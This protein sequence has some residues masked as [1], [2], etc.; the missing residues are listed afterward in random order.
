MI[1]DLLA[2]TG[3]DRSKTPMGFLFVVMVTL[4][5]LVFIAGGAWYMHRAESEARRQRQ[6]DDA[7]RKAADAP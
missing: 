3:F 4:F 1:L 6:A 7:N 5:M 2:E